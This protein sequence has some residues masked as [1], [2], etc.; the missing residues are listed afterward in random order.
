[1]KCIRCRKGTLVLKSYSN[2][3][4]QYRIKTSKGVLECDSCEHREVFR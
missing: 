1:M 4:G 3:N 2:S